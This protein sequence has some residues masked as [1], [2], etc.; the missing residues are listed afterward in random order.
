MKN[1][2]IP[3]RPLITLPA[4]LGSIFLLFT[5]LDGLYAFYK[6]P[7]VALTLLCAITVYAV[8]KM[9]RGNW[10]FIVLPSVATALLA[11]TVVEQYAAFGLM[12]RHAFW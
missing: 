9:E 11:A 1:T 4:N 12:S 10:V 5:P 2:L 6:L 3:M 8:F 7:L